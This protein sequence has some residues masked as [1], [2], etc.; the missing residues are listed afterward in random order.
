MSHS[1][2]LHPTRALDP[3]LTYCPRCGGDG[4]GIV[5]GHIFVAHVP[6]HPEQIITCWSRGKGKQVREELDRRNIPFDTREAEDGEKLPAAEPCP[7][8]QE[9]IA[10]HRSIVE[11]GGVYYRCRV[12][13]C[14]GVIRGDDPLA[15][16]VREKAGIEAPKPVGIEFEACVQHAVTEG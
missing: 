13:G 7:K 8:C 12:C 6:G 2:P 10:L 1:I 4:T 5:I 16:H 15:K 9:E 3:H 11:A 14:S